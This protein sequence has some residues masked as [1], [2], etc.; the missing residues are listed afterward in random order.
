MSVAGILFD[1]RVAGLP[2]MLF[3]MILDIL[4]VISYDVRVA[5]HP[6]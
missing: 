2:M 6:L 4:D 1:M 5:G 3:L